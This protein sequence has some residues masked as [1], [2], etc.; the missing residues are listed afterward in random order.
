MSNKV[1]ISQPEEYWLVINLEYPM[2][3]PNEKCFE[4]A[5]KLM[6]ELDTKSQEIS[7]FNLQSFHYFFEEHFVIRIEVNS[8]EEIKQANILCEVIIDQSVFKDKATYIMNYKGEWQQRDNALK[9]YGAPWLAVKNFFDASCKLQLYKR[10]HEP[11]LPETNE[12]K[13]IHC[14]LNHQGFD[15]MNEMVAILNLIFN[16]LGTNIS[17]DDRQPMLT[18]FIKKFKNFPNDLAEI[19]DLIEKEKFEEAKKKLGVSQ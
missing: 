2:N 9:G 6:I 5:N 7:D 10:F 18:E 17:F 8:D 3:N 16:R 14:F 13:L 15:L 11:I 1:I 12:Y 4:I 19:F